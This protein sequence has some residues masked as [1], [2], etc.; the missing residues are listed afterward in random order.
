MKSRCGGTRPA[1]HLE[2]R[3]IG[4]FHTHLGALLDGGGL[5][6]TP[7]PMQ[8][9][10]RPSAPGRGVTLQALLTEWPGATES[11]PLPLLAWQITTGRI[12]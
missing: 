6:P 9:S 8:P 2:A 1:C 3:G 12:L 7:I 11:P 5:K 10:P 4:R